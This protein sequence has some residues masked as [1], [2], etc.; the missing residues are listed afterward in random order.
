[1]RKEKL[2]LVV[3]ENTKVIV[4]IY[5]CFADKI[6]EWAE[7]CISKMK[8]LKYVFDSDTELNKND[9]ICKQRSGQSNLN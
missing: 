8:Y 7:Y 1:M 3:T 5:K 9:D 6:E 2:S 4:I